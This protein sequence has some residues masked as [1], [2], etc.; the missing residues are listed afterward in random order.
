MNLRQSLFKLYFVYEL[1][2]KLLWE[3][4][5]HAMIVVCLNYLLIQSV[6]SS[7]SKVTIAC[8]TANLYIFVRLAM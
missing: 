1:L 6:Q 4:Q 7:D 3:D 8:I 2:S 5:V